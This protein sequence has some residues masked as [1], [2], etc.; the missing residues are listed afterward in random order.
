MAVALLAGVTLLFFVVG[1]PGNLLGS[2]PRDQAWMASP[3][4]VTVVD[5]ETLRLGDRTL[6]LKGIAAPQ[7]GET[8]R[9]GDGRGFDCGNAA[10]EALS[11][12]LAGRAVA[13]RVQDRDAFGRGLGRCDAEG[14]DL[15]GAL[16]AAG[17]A[18]ASSAGRG[19]LASAEQ[20]ARAAGRGLW[21]SGQPEGWRLRR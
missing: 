20:E 16:V 5:G 11:R 7:R 17:F 13:C 15:N 8:C 14:V 4:E 9:G 19:S 3:A 10:A 1:L 12:L 21:A 2:A 18:V 6:R